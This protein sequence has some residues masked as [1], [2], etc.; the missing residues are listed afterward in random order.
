[1]LLR[2]I[3]AGFL[4]LCLVVG[5]L[6]AMKNRSPAQFEI[7]GQLHFGSSPD[8]NFVSRVLSLGVFWTVRHPLMLLMSTMAA[9]VFVWM[10]V[11]QARPDRKSMLITAGLASLPLLILVGLF[12]FVNVL[13]GM[14]V[15]VLF[16][17]F[18]PL[19]GPGLV[20][21]NQNHEVV[22]NVARADDPGFKDLIEALPWIGV[23]YVITGLISN[24]IDYRGLFG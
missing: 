11:R 13:K 20:E 15:I 12:G 14:V 21:V 22:R 18:S 24:W 2:R 3:L 8:E 7:D 4:G 6:L 10:K 1:M 19:I 5:F 17:L 23:I 9:T 16:A